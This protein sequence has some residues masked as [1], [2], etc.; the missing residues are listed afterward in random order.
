MLGPDEISKIIIHGHGIR[1]PL[2]TGGP[3]LL[4]NS[5]LVGR[6]A[7]RESMLEVPDDFS[8]YVVV[9]TGHFI[10]QTVGGQLEKQ[11]YKLFR[12]QT[13]KPRT[14][15]VFELLIPAN[16]PPSFRKTIGI[17][18]IKVEYELYAT[19][20]TNSNRS[21]N[22]LINIDTPFEEIVA[23]VPA[24]DV[25]TGITLASPTSHPNLKVNAVAK[26]KASERVA[27]VTNGLQFSLDFSIPG[28]VG[29]WPSDLKRLVI[30]Y[31]LK[32]TGKDLLNSNSSNR[33]I[34]DAIEFKVDLKTMGHPF[35]ST[36]K[37]DIPA[38]DNDE[39][40]PGPFVMPN[41]ECA[42][43][44]GH[45]SSENLIFTIDYTLIINFSWEKEPKKKLF[46][47][48][49]TKIKTEPAGSMQIPVYYFSRRDPNAKIHTKLKVGGVKYH[50][51]H[52][53]DPMPGI[54]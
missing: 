13:T 38:M 11:V 53:Q 16:I 3:G 28:Q 43:D 47:L 6:V 51:I 26:M 8:N 15:G 35:S 30:G 42:F 1:E 21:R 40:P 4:A 18:T 27:S 17:K 14:D 46:S 37:L 34:G 22:Y 50:E 10:I 2:T 9:F 12:D 20:P 19:N 48:G 36:L 24:D 39:Y 7:R 25:H 5:I 44:S 29:S 45:P 32:I 41:A 54:M 52:K 33:K 49:S 23:K 31:E